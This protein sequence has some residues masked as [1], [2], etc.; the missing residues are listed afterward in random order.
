MKKEPS[1][2]FDASAK[3]GVISSHHWAAAN[4][5]IPAF[6]GYEEQLA[7]VTK[8]LQEDK[9]GI[10]IFALRRK[11]QNS[12]KEELIAPVNR[13]DFKIR[14]NDTITADVIVTNKNIGHSFP[15]ELRDF[16]EAYVEFTVSDL[17]GKTLF[18]SGY[19]K[20]D[21]ELDEAAHAYKTH[22]VKE[23]GTHNV[24][25][26]IWKTKVVA[27]NSAI[28][29]GRS[30]LARYKFTIPSGIGGQIKLLAK[31]QYRRFTRVYSDYVLGK[32]VDLPIVT[33]ATSERILNTGSE[34]LKEI[35]DP[36]A[37]PDWRRWNN[38]GIALFDQRQFAESADA[39]DEVIDFKNDYRA[40]AYT[41]KALALI[42]LSDWKDADKLIDKALELDGAN[43]RALFQRGR[44]RRVGSNLESA[45]EDFKT[46]LAKYPRDRMTL[47]QLG[48]LAKIKSESVSPEQRKDQLNTALSYYERILAIDPEDL[49]A[50][51]NCMLI[52]QKLGIRDKARVS[53]KIF[54][55][56][57]DDPQTTPLASAFLQGNPDIGNESL[58]FHTHNLL[59]FRPAAEKQSYFVAFPLNLVSL[60]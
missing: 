40:F 2:Y 10:D 46:V 60:K 41:N 22:L 20:P 27:Q 39:F 24:L 11:K 59:G 14:E 49:G 34:N 4:T 37:M 32:S 57:K 5:A 45:E 19:I 6:Y 38:Y 12:N 43:L 8:F 58:L 31:L 53:A 55:D 23:D 7:R 30:D 56:L 54:Q 44:I 50:H 28:Q 16:Y 21:G 9:M 36:K 51:Y 15:P 42:E 35:V 25:H 1:K 26:F 47:Q 13:K 33:M 18:K 52:Y 48:E 3:D 17:E 29:S